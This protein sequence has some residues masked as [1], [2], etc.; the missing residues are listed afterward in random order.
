LTRSSLALQ[1]ESKRKASNLKS[2]LNKALKGLEMV[3]EEEFYDDVPIKLN[4]DLKGIEK[5]LLK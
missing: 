5:R 3:D 4:D 2:K 1:R